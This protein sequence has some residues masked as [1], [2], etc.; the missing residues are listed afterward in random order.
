M[1]ECKALIIAVDGHSSTGKSTVAKRLAARL[2]YAYIDTGA[3][4]RAVTLEAMRRGLVKGGTIGEEKLRDCLKKIHIGFHYNADKGSNET[5]LNGECVEDEIR[6]ME[7]SANVSLVAGLGFVREFLV[8]QQREMGKQGGVVMDGRDIGSVV[9]P[10]AEVKFFMTASPEV[11]AERRYK[12]LTEK[13]EKVDYQEVEKNVR[14]RDYLDEHRE[15]APLKK[16]EDAV[17]IDN[18]HM[19]VEEEMEL[20]LRYIRER[21]SGEEKDAGRNR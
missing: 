6:G 12:E 20:M 2:G 10:Q 4:Y 17:L 19:T 5:Y 18:S 3:M 16:T 11:R 7:V 8:Q 14:K 21:C 13:G 9:F 15:I 1:E